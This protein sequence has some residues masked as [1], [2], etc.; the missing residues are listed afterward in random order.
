MNGQPEYNPHQVDYRISRLRGTP[1]GCR[2]IHDLLEFVGTFC[3]FDRPASYPHPLLHIDGWEAPSGPPS[4]KVA[5]LAG[6]IERLQIAI[7]QV[8]RFLK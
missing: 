4:E 5:D 3:R 7:G 1:L 6:A 2:R 8:Q